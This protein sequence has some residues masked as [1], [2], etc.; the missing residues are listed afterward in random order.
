MPEP[1]REPPGAGERE[2]TGR[3]EVV[4]GFDFGTRRI[5]TAIG[6]T[7]TGTARAL[8]TLEY[9]N[10]ADLERAIARL[11]REYAPRRLVVGVPYNMSGSETA[12][13]RPAH[14]FI[15]E[16]ERWFA[17]PVG[18]VDERL[19]SREAE[20]ALKVARREGIRRRR[21][22]RADVDR[23]AARILVERWLAGEHGCDPDSV[24]GMP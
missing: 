22:T 6:D 16:L 15:R 20:A 13:T 11:I 12:L 1:G 2:A 4:L 23:E 24:R 3:F 14:R 17:L 18:V 19:S 5:G 10:R 8:E 9:R 21:T 7:I